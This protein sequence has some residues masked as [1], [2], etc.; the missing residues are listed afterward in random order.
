MSSERQLPTDPLAFVRDCVRRREVLWTYHVDMS[1]QKRRLSRTEILD[2]VDTYEVVESYPEDKKYLP[3]YLIR[4]ETAE[5]PLHVLFAADVRG[6]NVRVVTAY[7]PD[8]GEWA[9]S[10]TR[11]VG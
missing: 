2:T 1:L 11:R 8:P 10:G 6:A 7:R 9:D 5:G 3:S 4:T